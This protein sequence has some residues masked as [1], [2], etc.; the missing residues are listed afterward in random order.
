MRTTGRCETQGL[1][2]GSTR[3]P[4]RREPATGG[5]TG[6]CTGGFCDTIGNRGGFSLR[7]CEYGHNGG[8][9]GAV[10]GPSF[11]VNTDAGPFT[12]RG[13]RALDT[14]WHHLAGVYDGASVTLYVDGA[15]FASGPARGRLLGQ[16][17]D[18]AMGHI[19]DGSARFRGEIGETCISASAREEEWVRTRYEEFVAQS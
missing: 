18:I 11:I 10:G 16:V 6:G 15:I 19:A 12:A 5:C 7:A 4:S 14:G 3:W 13:K 8:L 2:T 9:G 1:R 17:E